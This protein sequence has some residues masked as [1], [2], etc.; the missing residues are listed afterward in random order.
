M[1]TDRRKPQGQEDRIGHSTERPLPGIFAILGFAVFN[2]VVVVALLEL[3]SWAI[4]SA[5]HAKHL[6]R[7]ENYRQQA[8]HFYAGILRGPRSSG[9]KNTRVK[10]RGTPYVPFLLWGSHGWVSW[11]V[12]QRRPGVRQR[13]WRR[14]NQFGAGGVHKPARWHVPGLSV[15]QPCMEPVYRIGQPCRRTCPVT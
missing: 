10:N 12:R 11:K 8:R 2:L 1:I 14:T 13:V 5:Y 4:W 3:G 6:D 9:K 15:D 7:P